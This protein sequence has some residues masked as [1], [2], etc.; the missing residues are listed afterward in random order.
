MAS[1]TRFFYY[2]RW[3]RPGAWTRPPG[4]L[5]YLQHPCGILDQSIPGAGKLP[6]ACPKN[7][8]RFSGTV[9]CLSSSPVPNRK[10]GGAYVA[11]G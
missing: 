7:G 5:P 8:T 1:S 4:L 2:N 11:S 10:P 3:Q 6:G 9:L